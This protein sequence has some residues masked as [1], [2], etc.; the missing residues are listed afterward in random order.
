MKRSNVDRFVLENID[1]IAD[2]LSH[3]QLRHET[4]SSQ[5]DGLTSAIRHR[6]TVNNERR[7]WHRVD[8]VEH[9]ALLM[10]D[11]Q[12]RRIVL[13]TEYVDSYFGGYVD[14]VD[15]TP[16]DACEV[17]ESVADG[18]IPPHFDPSAR[19]VRLDARHIADDHP[20]R[21]GGLDPMQA[22]ARVHAAVRELEQSLKTFDASSVGSYWFPRS[23]SWCFVV[24]L[25]L[26]LLSDPLAAV[27]VPE[28]DGYRVRTVISRR[29]AFW[30]I[31]SLGM[32]PPAWLDGPDQPYDST[33]A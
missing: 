24:P 25:H 18:W 2:C 12:D 28:A 17:C 22:R 6:L 33:A 20:E 30:N 19:I 32:R 3:E 7:L 9:N 29:A 13:V 21:L 23:A 26:D 4:R 10:R 1:R 27:L 5:L 11:R 14:L 16:A 15:V 8:N 31:A